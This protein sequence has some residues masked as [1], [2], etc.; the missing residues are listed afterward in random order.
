MYCLCMSQQEHTRD[1]LD[2]LL[3]DLEN[4]ATDIILELHG[5]DS[6]EKDE[7]ELMLAEESIQNLAD[8]VSTQ[9]FQLRVLRRVIME[10]EASQ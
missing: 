2:Q 3:A 10:K 1:R 9:A 8:H 5:K 6:T 4:A 7:V